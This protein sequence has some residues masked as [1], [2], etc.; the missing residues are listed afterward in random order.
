MG[1][2]A[3]TL[4][5]KNKNNSLKTNKYMSA[6]RYSVHW[7]RAVNTKDAHYVG[8]SFQTFFF[9]F[10]VTEWAKHLPCFLSLFKPYKNPTSFMIFK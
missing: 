10:F 8:I 9:F 7:I 2:V 6:L 4:S 5:Q 1:D 3:I